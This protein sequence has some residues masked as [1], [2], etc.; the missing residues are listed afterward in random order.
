MSVKLSLLQSAR[1]FHEAVGVEG[2]LCELHQAA[3]DLLGFSQLWLCLVAPRDP[4]SEDGDLQIQWH[5][6]E[7]CAAGLQAQ[8][9]EPLDAAATALLDEVLAGAEAGPAGPQSS[10]PPLRQGDEMMRCVVPLEVGA[11]QWWSLLQTRP[12]GSTRA[13][14]GV[15]VADHPRLPAD[16]WEET[17]ALLGELVGV[18]GHVLEREDVGRI[19]RQRVSQVSHEL[20]T[21]LSSV[22]AFCEMLADGDA[23]A[24]NPKQSRFVR[25]ISSNAD[26]LQRIVED[27]LVISRLDAGT[28][29]VSWLWSPVAGLM[30]DTVMNFWPQ[31][32][33][34]SIEL[35][36]EAPPNLP[37]VLT[38]PQR[39][40]EAL[41]N[42]VDNAIKYSPVGSQIRVWAAYVDAAEGDPSPWVRVSV[43]DQGEG[44]A[45]EEQGKVFEEFYRCRNLSRDQEAKGS[46][47]GLAI[48][49]RLM[50]LLG[51][52]VELSSEVGKG[53]TF[54]LWLPTDGRDVLPPCAP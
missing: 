20:R 6:L 12:T 7:R 43:T 17:R 25:R 46:G 31:S 48:V 53:S 54:S 18:A 13:L 36:V 23:G 42:L 32:G 4:G 51:G 8:G 50:A 35:R 40:Q 19:H 33:A 2:M 1:R 41:A 44:I 9:H 34:R 5:E 52:K 47:L 29:L 21:P 45:P 26:R 14:L 24:L 39:L 38:D 37:E 15:V 22:R 3:C 10:L 28:A 30:E 27:L 16:E 49:K 11:R